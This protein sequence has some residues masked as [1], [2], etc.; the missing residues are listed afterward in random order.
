MT[1]DC[2]ALLLGRKGSKGLPGKNT[3]NI[4]G[5]PISHYSILAALNSKYV[6]EL[7]LSTDDNVIK[8]QAN[9]FNIQVIER[10]KELCT[11]EALF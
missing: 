8:T 9:E 1:I 11:D 5:R 6:S 3:M 2:V 7:Y 10:P 4:L